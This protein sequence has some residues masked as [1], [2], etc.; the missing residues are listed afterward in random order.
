[1][2]DRKERNQLFNAVLENP[3]D[4]DRK[5]VFADWLEEHGDGDMG[6]CMRWCADWGRHPTHYP[7]HVFADHRWQWATTLP[8]QTK[9]VYTHQL[10]NA[11]Y[12]LMTSAGDHRVQFATAWQAFRRLS[13]I[14]RR[15]RV[16]ELKPRS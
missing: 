9:P 4:G 8:G 1:M 5:L 13:E 16:C 2:S 6:Y 14:I 15:M 3:D 10:P 12:L 7:N 11:V